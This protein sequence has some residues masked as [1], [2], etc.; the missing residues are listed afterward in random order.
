MKIELIAPCCLHLGNVW[1]NGQLCEL[2]IALKFPSWQMT[3]TTSDALAVSGSRAQVAH[4]HATRLGLKAQ[5]EIDEGAPAFMGLLSDEMLR[6][7]I[8]R[9]ANEKRLNLPQTLSG[10]A[11]LYG[12]VSLVNDDG[13]ASRQAKIVHKDEDDDWVFVFVL[14]KAPD[15]LDDDD[16]SRR[17]RDLRLSSS[18]L[19]HATDLQ[20]QQLFE[21][22]DKDDFVLFTRSLDAIHAANELA[23]MKNGHALSI[24]PDEQTIFDIMRDNGALAWGR[25]LTGMGLYGLVKGAGPSREMRQTLTKHLGYF[26]PVIMASICDNEGA[27]VRSQE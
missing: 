2:G 14:H 13:F 7:C 6:R 8:D 5:I 19:E 10:H 11:F 18:F 3:A 20:A 17:L 12:G 22:I 25:A 24:T 26:G 1:H 21:A 4:A 23:L 16:E 15:D 9:I 27:K